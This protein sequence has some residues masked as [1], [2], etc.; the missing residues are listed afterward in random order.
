[1]ADNSLQPIDDNLIGKYLAG[2][3]DAAESER[4]RLW[5]SQ[6]NSDANANQ[7]E[8]ERF[9]RIWETAAQL[10][11]PVET[12][13]APVD[14]DAAWQ[15]MR[16]RMQGNTT[17]PS[18][19]P[20]G[21]VVADTD[22]RSPVVKPLYPA[23]QTSNR[24]LPRYWQVAA[25]VL[26][27]S[28]FGWLYFQNSRT[29]PIA[30]LSIASRNE[31]VQKTLPDGSKVWLK[32]GSRLNYPQTFADESREV[33]LTGEA[34]F[35]VVPNPSRPF[36]IRAAETTVQVLG[37]SFSVRAYENDVRVAVRTGK[38]LFAAKKKQVTLI[39]NEQ[40]TFDSK[41]DTIR[42]MLDVE[43]NLF[44][45]RTGRLAFKNARLADIVQTINDVYRADVRLAN[46][47]L[48]NCA[49]TTSFEHNEPLETV[50]NVTAESLGLRITRKGDQITLDG[51][52]CQE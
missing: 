34:F 37:T 29:E 51:E 6:P 49:L 16:S 50:V 24:W 43:P 1:M 9:E 45:Y 8:F 15:K 35:E 10:K 23:N 30:Q 44:A 39:R 31:T 4:V 11:K 21:P 13:S 12:Q 38:V 32:R 47:R 40:A 28:A 14:T 48:N 2:E 26:L 18:P 52:G 33:T 46:N 42:K 3:T 17:A 27:A 36:R 22:V 41:A 7:R 20:V 5:L 19:P 25:V